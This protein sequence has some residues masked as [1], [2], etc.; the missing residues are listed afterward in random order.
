MWV[1]LFY[2]ALEFRLAGWLLVLYQKCVCSIVNIIP[3]SSSL[4]EME[5]CDLW[6]Y[7]LEG[8]FLSKWQMIYKTVDL[9]PLYKSHICNIV[10]FFN[11]NQ[12]ILVGDLK[13][14]QK[15]PKSSEFLEAIVTVL[16]GHIYLVSKLN[17]HY[18][19]GIHFA[20]PNKPFVMPDCRKQFFIKPYRWYSV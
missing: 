1:N 19:F 11:S 16:L 17:L 3:Y 9:N 15:H 2:F 6:F 14:L 8:F 12:P 18:F 13:I 10:S 20:N 7:A 5:W 4:Q